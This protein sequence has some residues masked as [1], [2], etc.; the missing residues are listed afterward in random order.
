RHQPGPECQGSTRSD[1]ASDTCAI[2]PHPCP[3]PT[4]RGTRAFGTMGRGTTT[5]RV[6]QPTRAQIVAVARGWIGTPYH[7]QASMRGVGAD[8]PG[9]VRGVWRELGGAEA[10]TPPAYSRDWAEAAGEE[11][12]LAAAARHLEPIDPRSADAGDVVVFRLRAGLVA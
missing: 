10:E 9:L 2:S 4:S 6:D 11:T 8:R 5:S 12:L 7:H 3:L 1:N